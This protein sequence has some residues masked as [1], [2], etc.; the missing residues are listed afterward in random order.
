MILTFGREKAEIGKRQ[1]K[2]G[3]PTAVTGS[4][5]GVDEP[6]IASEAEGKRMTNGTTYKKYNALIDKRS[7]YIF[8]QKTAQ[9]ACA[10]RN[11]ERT[12]MIQETRVSDTIN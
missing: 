7:N 6:P 11:G 8:A 9:I 3:K 5:S 4:K 2:E 10:N 1:K 12:E